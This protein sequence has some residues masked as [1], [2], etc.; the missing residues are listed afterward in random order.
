MPD[1]RFGMKRFGDFIFCNNPACV[2][3][4]KVRFKADCK[5]CCI[6]HCSQMGQEGKT[7]KAKVTSESG[8]SRFA[9]MTASDILKLPF[10]ILS[11]GYLI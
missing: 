4:W 6:A 10:I 9:C 5:S 8:C 1:D 3:C 11:L 7:M 2:P